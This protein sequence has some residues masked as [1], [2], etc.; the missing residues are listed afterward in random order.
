MAQYEVEIR[1]VE[2][3]SCKAASE[4][5]GF[6]CDVKV[7]SFSEFTGEQ[8]AASSIRLVESDDGWEVIQ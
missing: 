8:S 3:L 1:D 5:S 7:T 6:V 2:K 4:S